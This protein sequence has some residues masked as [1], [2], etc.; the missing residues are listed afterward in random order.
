MAIALQNFSPEAELDPLDA[1][2][3]VRRHL[4]DFVQQILDALYALSLG[5]LCHDGSSATDFVEL[6]IGRV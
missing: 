3:A 2:L 5:Y 6:G 1:V 4:A